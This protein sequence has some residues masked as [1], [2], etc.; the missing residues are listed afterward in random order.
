MKVSLKEFQDDAVRQL[1]TKFGHARREVLSGGD[2]QALVLSSP[3]GSG[4]TLM[5]TAFMEVA[6]EGDGETLGGDPEAT[7][8]WLSD[9]PDLNEQTRRKMLGTSTVFG[10]AEVVTVDN[11]FDEEVFEPGRVY[12]LNTQKLGRDRQ[13]VGTSDSRTFTIWDT[14]NN[15][16]RRR[17]GS[18]VMILDEAHKGM[19]QRAAD[20][21]AARTIVQKFVKGSPGELDPIKLILG[22]SAT[23]DR[24]TNLL[25]GVPDILPRPVTVSVAAV[26]DSGLIKDKVLVYHPS[27]GGAADWS[28]LEEASKSLKVMGE[29]WAQYAKAESTTVIRPL[30]VVQVEDGRG[31]KLTST[32]IAR[33]LQVVE[34][35]IGK[36]GDEE[37]AHSFQ[38][39]D[40]LSVNGRAIRRVAPPDIQ[41]DD[42]LR[43]VLFKLSLNTGWDCPRAEVMMSFRRAVDHTAI[44]QLVG[45]MVRTPLARRVE[46]D[47]LLNTVALY[48]PNYDRTAVANVVTALTQPGD[49]QIAAEVE[50]GANFLPELT[51]ATGSERY[52]ELLENIPCYRATRA[53]KVS[54]VRRLIALGRNLEQAGLSTGTA[55]AAQ[56]LVVDHLLSARQS[57][58]TRDSSFAD[59]VA[60]M[61]EVTVRGL[62]VTIGGETEEEGITKIRLHEANLQDLFAFCDKRLGEGL[63][64]EFVRRRVDGGS[65][66]DDAKREL[67]VLLTDESLLQ[68]LEQAAGRQVAEYIAAYQPAINALGEE[69]RVQFARIRR[70]AK[71]PEPAFLKLPEKIVGTKTGRR[72]PKHLYVDQD[73]LYPAVVTAW[74]STLLERRLASAETL[75]WL[76]NPP[77]KEWSFSVVYDDERAEKANM[78]PD[79]IVLRRLATGVVVDIVEPHRADEGDAARK[80][81]GLATYADHHGDRFGRIELISKG[82]DDVFRSLNLNDEA[83]RGAAKLVTTTSSVVKLFEDYG[84][85]MSGLRS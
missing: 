50:E 19:M 74:E 78:Y 76:R 57:A 65:T 40:T 67:L 81:I 28:L 26:R 42:R 15:T 69:D 35:V 13:M 45:R 10:P 16:T 12:F 47:E 2:R 84:K 70:S 66:A 39:G 37:I 79:F 85:P 48:L 30:L 34:T 1:V 23:P 71:D 68:Q 20:A 59:K 56:S 22:I 8:L 52:V 55:E 32:D 27:E 38:E 9:Q 63:H 31:R 24:F 53:P 51:R 7:F 11:D 62:S 83:S 18:F 14:I 43:L 75:A 5:A 64:L 29:H 82:D 80:V 54:N 3:T 46:R 72:W 21:A 49:E 6:L 60:G 61:A 58:L 36:L 17:P 77:R 25:R 33:V 4:K 73:G 44:A 41:D